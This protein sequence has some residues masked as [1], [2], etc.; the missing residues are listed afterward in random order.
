MKRILFYLLAVLAYCTT[1]NAQSIIDADEQRNPN[2]F[3]EQTIVVGKEATPY[4]PLRESDVV[5]KCVIWREIDFNEKFNQFFYFPLEASDN[6]QGRSSLINLIMKGVRSGDIPVYTDDDLTEV[7]SLDK[8]ILLL[9]GAGKPTEVPVLDA[10]GQP[11]FDEETGDYKM[12]TVIT[13]GHFD[14]ATVM[15]IR[16]K[17]YWYIDKQ[18]SRQKVRITGLTFFYDKDLQSGETQQTTAFWIP[19]DNM[20]VRKL[21][22]NANAYDED[23]DVTEN[24]YDNVFINRMFDSYVVRESNVYNR[25]IHEYLTGEDA[26]I[27]SQNIEDKLYNLESDMWEY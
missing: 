4:P 13:P 5:W 15:K 9:E 1:S 22:V 7:L 3:Y 23:N 10:D 24:S 6:T 19:M 2:D 17:E 8:A 12:T 14:S 21:F 20:Q 11:E 27:E 18:D 25:Y 26:V 16:L